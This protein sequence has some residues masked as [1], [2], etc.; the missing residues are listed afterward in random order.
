VKLLKLKLK[1]ENPTGNLGET[2][3][4]Q[5]AELKYKTICI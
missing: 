2:I 5:P 1:P 4:I 3:Y